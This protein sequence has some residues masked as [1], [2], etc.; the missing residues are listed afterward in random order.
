MTDCQRAAAGAPIGGRGGHARTRRRDG[1]GV[2]RGAGAGRR[3]LGEAV[4][5][6]ARRTAPGPGRSTGIQCESR[7][8][9]LLSLTRNS[10]CLRPE[11]A[12]PPP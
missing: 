11:G 12:T 10:V 5:A 6:E 7:W 8:L 2:R 3:G 4:V 9:T 1:R